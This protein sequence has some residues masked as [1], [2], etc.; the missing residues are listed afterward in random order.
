[1]HNSIGI[2]TCEK[3][4]L[5]YNHRLILF[6]YEK[7]YFLQLTAVPFHKIKLGYTPVDI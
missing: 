3:L 2:N 4:F 1:M 5:N 6:S 7:G